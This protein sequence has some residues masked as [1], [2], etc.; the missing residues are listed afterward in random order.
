MSHHPSPGAP[1]ALSPQER[2]RLELL[3]ER[4]SQ[5]AP[6][7]VP[8][9][10]DEECGEHKAL[11]AEL[12]WLLAGLAGKDR[13]SRLQPSLA[14]RVG[15]TIGPYRLLEK[16]G[17]G[18]M[19]EVYAADQ[20]VPVARRVAL[21]V[22][23][24]GMDS[25]QVIARFEAERQALARMSHPHIAQVF[26]AGTTAEG[27]PYFVMELV[28]GVPIND[29]CDRLKLSTRERIELLIAV[30]EGVQHAHQKGIIHRD[31]KPSNL[32]VMNQDGRAVPKIIDFG[33]ARATT[34]RLAERTLFTLQGQILG[35]LDYMSP[36]QADPTGLD[37]DTRSDI[38]SLGVVLYQLTSGLLPFEH[39][40]ACGVPLS[41]IQRTIRE[42]DPPTP[43][44]RLRRESGSATKVASLHATDERTLVRQLSGDLDWITLK[45]LEKDPTRRYGS[46]SELADDLKRHLAH[47][48]VLAGRPGSFYRARKFVRRNR[49]RVAAALLITGSALAGIYGFVS[50]RLEAEASAQ[51]ARALLPQ[52]DAYRLKK[53]C[54]DAEGLFPSHPNKLP[55]LRAWEARAQ[56]LLAGL[57][58]HR[59]E[60]DRVRTR[61]LPW[62]SAERE[63]DRRT[64]PLAE[65]LDSK[66]AEL[67][68]WIADLELWMEGDATGIPE[69]RFEEAEER[70]SELEPAIVALESE[71]RVRRSYTFESDEDSWRHEMLSE[72]VSGLEELEDPVRG[73]L[74]PQGVSAEYGWSIPR[75]CAF[76]S[77]LEAGFVHGGEFAEAWSSA[78]PAIHSAYPELELAPQ[79]ALLPLGPDPDSGLWEFA[80]LGTGPPARRGPDGKLVLEESTGIVFV[81]LPEASYLMGCQGQDPGLANYDPAA[82]D[83]K[84]EGPPTQVEVE[85]FFLSKFELT[86]A[87]WVLGTGTN[88]SM[89]QKGMVKLFP[90]NP[91]NQVTWTECERFVRRLGLVLPTEEQW[92]YGARAGTSSAWWTGDK[93]SDLR[94]G[95][96]N[97]VGRKDGFFALTAVGSFRANPFGL[98]DMLGNVSE[99]CANHPYLYGTQPGT[100][101][102]TL[103]EQ[104]A[105]GGNSRSRPVDARS[106]MRL[107]GRAETQLPVLGLR[108]A[109]AI[110]P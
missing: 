23:K 20:R 69:A 88:P 10:L 61:V 46:A 7:E 48:P 18:G 59:E 15:S 50:G 90:R 41:E 8:K 44:T 1:E 97:L 6:D 98:Y 76:A 3:F 84:R 80:H 42:V 4:A 94:N 38:Y 58:F 21:K 56:A 29:Y 28:P 101:P 12:A 102:E 52:A 86:Q 17:E 78:L 85:A 66:Q 109:R 39:G 70:I 2:E 57:A 106:A 53:L 13:L 74:A 103:L 93:A 54:A 11:R 25:A 65:E 87:Q 47:E 72:L 22:I 75:R 5:L 108:P 99:W 83:S 104:V 24:P 96:E 33:V 105:R 37:I 35:T 64:H 100:G 71:V 30:C 55:A 63:R 73:L 9:F 107:P 67:A 31:L 89:Y 45:A 92:E 40:S 68:A 14:A 51:V 26:D 95:A 62:D 110:D 27:L 77:E 60:R 34:G 36:E 79:M 82:D 81:L 91:V 49:V 16:I 32:L 19:G 43:S